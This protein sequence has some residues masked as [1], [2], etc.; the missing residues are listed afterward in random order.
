MSYSF[1]KWDKVSDINN[2]PAVEYLGNHPE[3]KESDEIVLV[4]ENDSVTYVI[5]TTDMRAELGLEDSVDAEATAEAYM[6]KIASDNAKADS[7]PNETTNMEQNISDIQFTL[8]MGG[9]L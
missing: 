6:N 2:C 4:S 8:M 1:L 3:V 9:L 7:T 5:N